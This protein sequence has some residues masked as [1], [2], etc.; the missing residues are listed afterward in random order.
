M[1]RKSCLTLPSTSSVQSYVEPFLSNKQAGSKHSTEKRSILFRFPAEI[2][3]NIHEKVFGG[4]VFSGMHYGM[5]GAMFQY[6]RH[7]RE[8]AGRYVLLDG[9]VYR[10]GA[11]GS[12]T[13]PFPSQRSTGRSTQKLVSS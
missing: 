11:E 4:F 2:R 8:R 12:T 13:K 10:V 1:G 6:S 7:G 3:N 5:Q 9:L